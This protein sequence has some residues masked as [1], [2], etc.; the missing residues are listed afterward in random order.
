MKRAAILTLGAV[1]VVSM[2]L[3]TGC[4]HMKSGGRCGGK[5]AG[6]CG[7]Q[8]CAKYTC[9]K[10]DKGTV[11]EGARTC[12]VC[13]AGFISEDEWERLEESATPAN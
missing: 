9:P 11:S 7:M 10:C 2:L 6:K 8:K 13:K 3:S 1:V 5:G 4:A 12:P